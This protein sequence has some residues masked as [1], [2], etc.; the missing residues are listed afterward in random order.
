MP[1][2][3]YFK[4]EGRKVMNDMKDRYGEKKGENVFYATAN[5]TGMKPGGSNN[6]PK[7]RTIGQRIANG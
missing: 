7:R 3:K 4:G 6:R 1:L 2:A 5:K